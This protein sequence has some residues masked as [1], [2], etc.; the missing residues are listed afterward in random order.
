MSSTSSTVSVP[1]VTL[2]INKDDTKVDFDRIAI[3]CKGDSFTTYYKA[4][5][6]IDTVS[7]KTPIVI[8]QGSHH[9]VLDYLEDIFDL[10][11]NDKDTPSCPCVDVLIPGVPVVGLHPKNPAAKELVI[12][13][14]RNWC[15]YSQR[16]HYMNNSC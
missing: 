14:V 9:D 16:I 2:C 4:D 10:L 7:N 8:P 13:L 1:H 15:K 5:V 6:T 3:Y 11:M 12:R